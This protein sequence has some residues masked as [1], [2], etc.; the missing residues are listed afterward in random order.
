MSDFVNKVLTFAQKCV[1]EVPVVVLGSGAS[2]AHGLPGMGALADHL[3]S[4]IQSATLTP[5][6]Q[7]QWAEF[8]RTLSATDLETALTQVRV[9][10][11]LT[12]RIVDLTWQL[13][14]AADK[15]VFDKA[16][17]GS[18]QL[19]LTRLFQ[20]LLASSRSEID[21]VTTNYDRLA[22]YAADAGHLCCC[23]GF[24]HGYIRFRMAE[25]RL[26]F[27]QGTRQAK[28]V[29]VWKVHGSL[30]W[31]ESSDGVPF[32]LPLFDG[33]PPEYRPLM[34][35]PGV[36]KFRRTHNEPF[37]TVLSL[38]DQALSAASACLCIGYGFNDEHIQ[39]KLIERVQAGTMPL[40]VITKELTP[41]TRDVLLKGRCRNFALFE[42][43]SGG[44]TKIY[45]PEQV[46]GVVEPG[47]NLWALPDFLDQVL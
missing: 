34:V 42:E 5:D 12:N 46:D 6:E 45:T 13:I 35:T 37:R 17:A 1:S 26:K 4:S 44:G 31:F 29:N 9:S 40:V 38:T 7:G 22:E 16:V 23:T 10:E 32:G 19:T 33:P 15:A 25:N 27:Q 41:K 36:E 2:A 43:A 24:A 18:D 28:T 39:P 8:T 11:A 21:V 30:D 20:H 14:V 47:L 3:V